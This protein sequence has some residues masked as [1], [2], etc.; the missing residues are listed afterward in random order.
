VIAVCVVLFIDTKGLCIA[1]SFK[2]NVLVEDGSNRL[3]SSVFFLFFIGF[4][5][6]NQLISIVV[7]CRNRC[8]TQLSMV[9]LTVGIHA[10]KTS[11]RRMDHRC[12]II[13]AEDG[14]SLSR[15]LLLLRCRE[16][17]YAVFLI[18]AVFHLERSQS[19]ITV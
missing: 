14:S 15:V 19:C 10:E 11:K 4:H 1:S 6:I 13:V 17:L 16:T 5:R 8:A 18:R 7:N 2:G 12:R 3:V 9:G